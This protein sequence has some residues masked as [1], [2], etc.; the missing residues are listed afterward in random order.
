M[1]REATTDIRSLFPQDEPPEDFFVAGGVVPGFGGIVP[2]PGFGGVGGGSGFGGVGE[3]AG[4]MYCLSPQ[5]AQYRSLS[6]FFVSQFLQTHLFHGLF[7]QNEYRKTAESVDC[8]ILFYQT[9]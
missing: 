7:R 4:L 6:S 3:G 5:Q 9:L 8:F 1:I 2:V